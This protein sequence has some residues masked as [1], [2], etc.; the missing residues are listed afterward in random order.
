VSEV[1]YSTVLD[2]EIRWGLLVWS[3]VCFT[4]TA[5]ISS[6]PTPSKGWLLLSV[7]LG[8]RTRVSTCDLD[9]PVAELR[10]RLRLQD[11]CTQ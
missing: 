7:P 2:L 3:A 6:H 8:V 11:G 10:G 9:D 4:K 1:N 5:N